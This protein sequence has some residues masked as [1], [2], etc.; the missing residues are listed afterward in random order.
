MGLL[1]ILN[2]PAQL[3]RGVF[4]LNSVTR[5]ESFRTVSSR[6]GG[7]SGHLMRKHPE[8]R[9]K[10]VVHHGLGASGLRPHLRRAKREPEE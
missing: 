8:K 6:A 3:A 2:I 1:F 4:D 7:V 10:I 9:A 5:I